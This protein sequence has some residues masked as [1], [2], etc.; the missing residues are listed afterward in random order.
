VAFEDLAG[1]RGEG[2]KRDHGGEDDIA[3]F[4]M[5]VVPGVSD[6]LARVLAHGPDDGLRDLAGF[7]GEFHDA[8]QLLCFRRQRAALVQ[9]AHYLLDGAPRVI[10]GPRG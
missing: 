10:H 6:A 3:Q 5:H 8:Q 1:I 7:L 9:P 2:R 4:G